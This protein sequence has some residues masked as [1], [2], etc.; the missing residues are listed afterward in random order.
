MNAAPKYWSLLI[1]VDANTR[2]RVVKHVRLDGAKSTVNTNITPNTAPQMLFWRVEVGGRV[3]GRG[4]RVV[5]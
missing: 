1:I 5:E 3:A 2:G 4:R